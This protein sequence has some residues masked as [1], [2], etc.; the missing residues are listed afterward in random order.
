MNLGV[1]VTAALSVCLLLAASAFPWGQ[2]TEVAIVTTAVHVLSRGGTIPLTRL[3]RN[4]RDGAN[5]SNEELEARFRG[6][7]L[8]PVGAIENEMYLLQS[9]RGNRV[10]A[11]YAYRLGVLGKLVAT[12]TAPMQ[13]V[14]ASVRE[15]YY[16]SV[17]QQVGRVELELDDRQIV[18]PKPYFAEKL[19]EARQSQQ[20]ILQDYR[21]GIGFNGI[22]RS[23]MPNDVSR[24]VDAVADVWYTILQGQVIVANVPEAEV[25]NYILGAL[26]FYINRG[27]PQEVDSAYKRVMGLANETP[28]LREQIGDMFFDAGNYERAMAEYE[29][30]LTLDPSRREVTEKISQYYTEVGQ[31]AEEEGRLENAREAFAKATDADSL[32]P[33]APSRL[34]QVE[35]MIVA[36]QQRLQQAQD[37]I[38]RARELET[39]AEQLVFR[40]NLAEAISQLRQAHDAY[41]SVPD[42]FDVEY[43]VARQGVQDVTYRIREYTQSLISNSAELSGTGFARESARKLT[44]SAPPVSEN[45]L[46][47]MIQ[48]ELDREMAEL[49]R[50]LRTRIR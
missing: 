44:Q 20:D 36:R 10:D 42:E 45:A 37:A 43:T 26:R 46:Q 16:E 9:V 7:D 38:E 49:A 31:R 32:H 29:A 28:D 50:Q 21:E 11:Y 24:S 18:D 39:E 8:N 17:D 14:R 33:E 35:G 1:K 34:F 4:V 41:E 22:A 3:Q 15:S 30:V 40:G 5:I 2:Q 19:R 6:Y 13:D 47:K 12:V 48:A 23:K 27:N 25:Q